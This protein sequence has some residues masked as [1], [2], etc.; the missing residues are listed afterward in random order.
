MMEEA[1]GGRVHR[2]LFLP[3]LL[4]SS[5]Y[6]VAYV[7]HT[8][9]V[10]T[11]SLCFGIVITVPVMANANPRVLLQ[12]ERLS[13]RI[14]HPQASY[15]KD[16]KLL[17][18]LCELPIKSE[19]AWKAHLHSTGHTLRL[20][21]AHDVDTARKNRAEHGGAKKRKADDL[22][23]PDREDRKKV[24]SVTEVE[25]AVSTTRKPVIPEDAVA[26]AP[27]PAAVEEEQG[28][29]NEYAAFERE[30][31]VLDSTHAVPSA[32]NAAATISAAPMSV[33]DIAAQAREEQSAQRGKR[34]LEIEGEQEDAARLMADEFDEMV[35]L[36]ERVKKLRERRDA[37]KRSHQMGDSDR[38]SRDAV[39]SMHEAGREVNG[40]ANDDDDEDDSGNDDRDDRDTE[41][42]EVEFD[43]WNF[44]GR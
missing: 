38:R 6:G 30:M 24:K 20:S 3:D 34:D 12:A 36:E 8:G 42:E 21:R 32:L 43:D 16:G 14:T 13:R 40:N 10:A 41:E 9:P 25:E 31:A 33:A 27:E 15:T 35:G 4:P 39:A 26:Q 17:C 7:T 29:D 5:D 18:N 28:L 44:G 11:L 22:D 37:L 2:D 23:N 1:T 19:H